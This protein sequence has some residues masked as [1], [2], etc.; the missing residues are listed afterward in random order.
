MRVRDAAGETIECRGIA[1]AAGTGVSI[2]V[3][4]AHDGETATVAL[5]ATGEGVQGP[6]GPEGPQGL[7]GADGAQGPQ[8]IQGL[9][10]ADGAQ[11]PQGIQGPPGNDGAQGI[12]GVPGA[13]GAAGPQGI[14]GPPGDAGPQGIQGPEGPQGPQGI[15]GIQGEPGADGAGGTPR[16]SL[17]AH[18]TFTQAKTNIGSAFSNVYVGANSDGKSVPVDTT[19]KTQARLVVCWNKIGTGTHTVQVVDAAGAVLISTNVVSGRNDSGLAAIPAGMLDSTD[20]FRL[21][22]KSTTAADDPVF[23]SA[24]LLLI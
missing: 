8:G 19:G 21:Q 6:A 2:D 1:F 22:A 12:Q 5:S 18:W 14:Q 13:D 15:Q 23:E 24:A 20:F 17:V 4:I 9:P 16:Q 10:G 7:P 11:G 3:G